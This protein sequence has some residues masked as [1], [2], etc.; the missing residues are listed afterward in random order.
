MLHCFQTLDG[1]A[2]ESLVT[3]PLSGDDGRYGAST[4]GGG[5]LWCSLETPSESST[6]SSVGT[7]TAAPLGNGGA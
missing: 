5:A 6:C 4:S 2:G 7:A 3:T 1:V